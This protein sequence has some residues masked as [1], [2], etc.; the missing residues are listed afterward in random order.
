VNLPTRKLE[1]V[2]DLAWVDLSAK[3]FQ[4]GEGEE[5]PEVVDLAWEDLSAKKF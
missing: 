4:E 2:V 5:N 1:E 3:K